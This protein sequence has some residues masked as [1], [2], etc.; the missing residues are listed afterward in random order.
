MNPASA[1]AQTVNRLRRPLRQGAAFA[2]HQLFGPFPG[3]VALHCQVRHDLFNLVFSIAQRPELAQLRQVEPHKL[4]YHRENLRSLTRA[5][6][7]LGDIAVALDPM[8]GVDIS[9]LLRPLRGIWRLLWP[10][11]P[12]CFW[13]PQIARFLPLARTGFRG[14]GHGVPHA[15]A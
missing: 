4:P 11:S 1:L 10:A 5:G 13:K 12:V 15:T 14:L 2:R 6:T 8:E 9:S 7:D 3:D